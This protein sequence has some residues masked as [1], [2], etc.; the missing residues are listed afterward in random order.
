MAKELTVNPATGNLDVV[1]QSDSDIVSND[2][3]YLK[4]DTYT[5]TRTGSLISTVWAK[6]IEY[7]IAR[8]TNNAITSI[9]TSTTAW[10]YTRDGNNKVTAKTKT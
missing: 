6:G 2:A 4:F 3:K 10:T 1:G 9:T 5:V 8:G 7:T